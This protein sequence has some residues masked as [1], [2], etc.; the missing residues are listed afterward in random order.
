MGNNKHRAIKSNSGTKKRFGIGEW[1]GQVFASMTQKERIDIAKGLK[2]KTN[3][4]CP[5]Q[6]NQGRVLCNKNGGVCSI[7]LYELSPSGEG[8]VA[9][10][11]QG[12]LR[13]VCPHRFDEGNYIYSWVGEVILGSPRPELAGEVG[14]LE[15]ISQSQKVDKD[16]VGRIDKVLAVSGTN[17]IAWC[18]LE[19]QAFISSGDAM[20]R[21]WTA[22]L[23]VTS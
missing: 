13:T 20:S 22:I 5:F 7:R 17:P 9:D 2:Q 6:D 10:G 3:R 23:Y 21:E 8:S 18:A 1:Y 19:A 14:F 16:D 12:R 15:K 4:P 11:N